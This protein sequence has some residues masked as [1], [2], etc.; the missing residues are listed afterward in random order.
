MLRILFPTPRRASRRTASAALR[1]AGLVGLSAVLA[2]APLHAGESAPEDAP[3][4]PTPIGKALEPVEPWLRHE[5]W[6]LRS[7]AAL[8]MRSR[9]DPG[10]IW[11][12]T[13][14]LHRENDTR[15]IGCA[16]AALE[17]R[18]RVD[19]IREGGV[20]LIDA[21]A[22]AARHDHPTV[23]ERARRI[24]MRTPPIRLGDDFARYEG[25]WKRGR[26]ALRLEQQR[27]KRAAEQQPTPP[28]SSSSETKKNPNRIYEHWER[29]RRHGLEMCIIL[30]HTG[31]MTP[32]IGA[33]KSRI[34]KLLDRVGTF[35]PVFRV[36][37]VTYDDRAMKR[38]AL[39]MQREAIQ[40]AFDRVGAGGGADPDEGV[41]KGIYLAMQQDQMGWSRSAQRVL[42]VVGDAPPHEVDVPRLLRHL[43]TSRVDDLY[44]HPLVVHTVSTPSHGTPGDV[45]EHFERIAEAGGGQHTSIRD[46]ALLVDRLVLLSFGGGADPER[47]RRWMKE[48]KGLSK[49]P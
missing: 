16:L 27:L 5:D 3:L 6:T 22:R 8:D 7:M 17:G 23:R 12:L 1:L 43:V 47:V 37:L 32:V 21:L 2:V 29:I 25:W 34:Q 44:D 11:L 10:L 14:L 9:S 39:S 49:K 36:G 15:V 38:I 46:A 18:P 26:E 13:R 28:T 20:T 33:A 41:D 19:L 24:M 4:V 48:I 30:D 31:S 40:K 42:V 45:V 35:V